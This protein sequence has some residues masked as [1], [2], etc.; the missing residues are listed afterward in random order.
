M[1]IR[2]RNVCL[3]FFLSIVVLTTACYIFSWKFKSSL[4][5]FL[6][7][8]S[9]NPKVPNTIHFALLYDE[10]DVDVVSKR[11]NTIDFISATC[12]LAVYFNHQPDEIILHTNFETITGKYWK[13][14]STIIGEKLKIRQIGRP[15]HV[16]GVALSSVHHA[17]DL[18]RIRTLYKYGGI[19]L[20]NPKKSESRFSFD[21]F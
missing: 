11:N 21:F 3:L 10:N 13:I 9:Y 17:S 18:V 8:P 19:F 20:G 15:T 14:V 2:A 6:P 5:Q 16:F 1:K 4:S 12:I 7:V